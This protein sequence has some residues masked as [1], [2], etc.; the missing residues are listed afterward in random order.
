MTDRYNYL[1]KCKTTFCN[2]KV[3]FKKEKRFFFVSISK[4][5]N[6]FENPDYMVWLG[7]IVRVFA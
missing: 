6:V 3:F 2:T 7:Y 5:A 1:V 4:S